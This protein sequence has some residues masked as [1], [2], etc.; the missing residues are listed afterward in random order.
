METS[1][2]RYLVPARVRGGGGGGGGADCRWTWNDEA[3][4]GNSVD[5]DDIQLEFP[6]WNSAPKCCHTSRHPNCQACSAPY[7]SSKIIFKF[8]YTLEVLINIDSIKNIQIMGFLRIQ[9]HGNDQSTYPIYKI[10]KVLHK[11]WTTKTFNNLS[12]NIHI[13]V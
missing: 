10:C 12:E 6:D 9:L 5:I 13:H 4:F 8:L 7:S 11:Y 3:E 1:H 2:L